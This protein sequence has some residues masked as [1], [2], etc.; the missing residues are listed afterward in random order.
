ME[1]L[2]RFLNEASIQ[3][4]SNSVY[5]SCRLAGLGHFKYNS[6]K[7]KLCTESTHRSLEW[8]FKIFLICIDNYNV[9]GYCFC[10]VLVAS[11]PLEAQR[12]DFDNYLFFSTWLMNNWMLLHLF[13]LAHNRK[14]SADCQLTINDI[15]KLNKTVHLCFGSWSLRTKLDILLLFHLQYALMT[16]Q[17]RK[18]WDQYFC[19]TYITLL[20]EIYF[21]AYFIYQLLLLAWLGALHNN[22]STYC[23]NPR[24]GHFP[25]SHSRRQLIQLFSVYLRIKSLHQSVKKLWQRVP[26]VLFLI[27]LKQ[28]QYL[29][30]NLY[31]IFNHRP[32]NHLIEFEFCVVPLLKIF[33]LAICNKRIQMLNQ[34]L[35]EH[36]FRIE[37]LHW[38][39]HESGLESAVAI[40]FAKTLSREVSEC[41]IFVKYAQLSSFFTELL[42]I[43]AAAG[44]A[45]RNFQLQNGI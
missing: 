21:C 37:F 25:S 33:I 7:E 11:S 31:K 6:Q 30:Y 20:F 19:E 8:L 9:L 18:I 32:I 5:L 23:L 42:V 16:L 34:Q 39:W 40:P 12:E 3:I 4:L 1:R 14:Y 13:R 17:L 22:L 43:S 2:E 24:Q 45:D 15:I 36:L 35:K 29:A 41:Q 26:G 28:T 44:R 38:N 10:F 27:L